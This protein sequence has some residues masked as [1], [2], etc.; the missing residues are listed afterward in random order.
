MAGSTAAMLDDLK[1]Q[2]EPRADEALLAH[3]IE[4]HQ[5]RVPEPIDIGEHDRLLMLL[6]L[7]PGELLDELL[8]RAEAA[9]QRH[10]SIGAH[11]HQVLS[12]MHVVDHDELMRFEQHVLALA[13]E[14]PG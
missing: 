7:R 4:Q 5:Q 3:P 14:A 2:L 8:E 10:E 6:E 1:M 13:Q 11:E 9:R 12:L